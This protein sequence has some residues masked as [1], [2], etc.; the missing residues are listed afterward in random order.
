MTFNYLFYTKRGAVSEKYFDATTEQEADKKAT[1]FLHKY[2]TL[3]T[4]YTPNFHFENG[5]LYS[6]SDL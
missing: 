1:A 3:Y 5:A 6:D 2:S 4:D